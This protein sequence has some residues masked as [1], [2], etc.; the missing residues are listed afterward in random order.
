ML[1]CSVVAQ[2]ASGFRLTSNNSNSPSSVLLL[3]EFPQIAVDTL[4]RKQQTNQTWYVILLIAAYRML[5]GVVVTHPP[6]SL[7]HQKWNAPTGTETP[8]PQL[9]TRYRLEPP[10]PI[11]KS[12][13]SFEDWSKNNQTRVD[14]SVS[15]QMSDPF[16]I[17][18]LT[19]FVVL[20]Q[21]TRASWQKI[22]ILVKLSA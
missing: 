11:L 3:T 13:C 18:I 19:H 17:V 4:E 15:E 12:L 1:Y 8:P 5:K 9:L 16:K 22:Y 2:K 6:A 14:E 20:A 10:E 21:V 7:V